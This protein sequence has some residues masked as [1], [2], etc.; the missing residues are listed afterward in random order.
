MVNI[1]QY[2]AK[3]IR[4]SGIGKVFA[5]MLLNIKNKRIMKKEDIMNNENVEKDIKIE[6]A[7]TA[8]DTKAEEDKS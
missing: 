6:G 2:L 1:L 8:N 4:K 3:S 7:D 5:D